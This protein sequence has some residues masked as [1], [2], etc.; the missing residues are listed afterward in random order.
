MN[1]KKVLRFIPGILLI[2]LLL[3]INISCS[4][5]KEE[6]GTEVQIESDA[7]QP[8]V[9]RPEELTFK[10]YAELPVWEKEREAFAVL[11]GAT[12]ARDID[13]LK[14]IYAQASG[15]FS[16]ILTN[17]Q[18]LELSEDIK[19]LNDLQIEVCRTYASGLKKFNE[20]GDSANLE[21]L[22]QADKKMAEFVKELEQRSDSL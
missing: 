13:G 19:E 12:K 17:L 1:N 2:I 6:P 22:K 4:Q 16:E 9:S 10:Q 18:G 15:L 8:E 11:S 14:S 21:V 7:V 20:T 5:K 3:F